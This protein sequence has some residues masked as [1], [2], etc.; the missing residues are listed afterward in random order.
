ML[1]MYIYTQNTHIHRLTCGYLS[2]IHTILLK[3]FFEGMRWE[4]LRERQTL[5]S[6]WS[7]MWSSIP[8]TWGHNL[9][10][11]QDLDALPRG[12][13]ILLKCFNFYLILRHV[14]WN[15]GKVYIYC[16]ED[17]FI[18]HCTS[19]TAVLILACEIGLSLNTISVVCYLCK[20]WQ[21][22]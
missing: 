14:V 7:P 20:T 5:Y 2:R 13:Q 12:P 21:V 22:T 8:W 9:S 11:N 1:Y 3:H 10:Q 6:V 17:E 18:L 15:S 16:D 4:R 19:V